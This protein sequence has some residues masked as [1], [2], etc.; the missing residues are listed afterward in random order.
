MVGHTEYGNALSL[1]VLLGDFSIEGG[2][3][4]CIQDKRQ[5]VGPDVPWDECI[6]NLTDM[7]FLSMDTS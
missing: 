6:F 7:I 3:Y 2:G 5:H 4:L 1:G